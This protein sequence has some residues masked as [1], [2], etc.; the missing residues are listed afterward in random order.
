MHGEQR[1]VPYAVN[2]DGCSYVWDDLRSDRNR[3]PH[4]VLRFG[5]YLG[6]WR[7]DRSNFDAL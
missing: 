4:F 5:N 6:Q 2:M 1:W 7:C 3:V